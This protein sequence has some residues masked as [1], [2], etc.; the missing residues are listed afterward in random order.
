MKKYMNKYIKRLGLL[1]RIVKRDAKSSKVLIIFDKKNINK[2]E[3]DVTI[4]NAGKML[5]ERIKS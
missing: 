1:T 2:D 3:T 4:Y 5:K